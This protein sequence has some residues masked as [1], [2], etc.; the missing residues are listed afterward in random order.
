MALKPLVNE[1]EL[2]DSISKGDEKA[3][4]KLFYAYSKPLYSFI[5]SIIKCEKT[6][7]EILNDVFLKIWK[8]KEQLG[9]IKSLSDYIF[10]ICRN[11]ALNSLR[12]IAKN[13]VVSL[14]SVMENDFLVTDKPIENCKLDALRIAISN[15]PQQQKKVLLLKHDGYKNEEVASKMRLS[16]NSV[17]KYQKL[18]IDNLVKA[19]NFNQ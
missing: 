2:I 4:E 7:E 1:Q 11:Y 17:K 10:I 9:N 12:T 18:A 8:Q 13:K 5:I 15:L 16:T 3:F 19:L 14:E 6:S